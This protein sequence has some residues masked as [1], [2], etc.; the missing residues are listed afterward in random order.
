MKCFNSVFK[1]FNSD[2]LFFLKTRIFVRS[3][4]LGIFTI[5]SFSCDVYFKEHVFNKDELVIDKEIIGTWILCDDWEKCNNSKEVIRVSFNSDKLQIVHDRSRRGLDDFMKYSG[6][7]YKYLDKKF[8]CTREDGGGISG[9]DY[10]NIYYY[11]IKNDILYLYEFDKTKFKDLKKNKMINGEIRE[12]GPYISSSFFVKT[13]GTELRK[14]IVKEGI[15]AFIC[16]GTAT[17]KR[18]K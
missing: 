12:M 10:Y 2:C 11:Y 15:E 8:I 16:K 3:F 7:T 13:E 17:L 5:F 1:I 9:T 18:E 4:L 14:L 6:Q